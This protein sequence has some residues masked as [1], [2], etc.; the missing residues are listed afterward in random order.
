[1][2]G[3]GGAAEQGAGRILGLGGLLLTVDHAG[4]LVGQDLLGLVQLLVLP[5]GHLVDLLQRQEG[6][7]PNALHDVGVVHVAPVLVELE[8]A[9]LVG[10]QPDRVAGG[11]AHLLALGVGQQGD[12]HGVGVLAQ[13]AADQLGAAQ[14]IAPLVVAA[15]LHVAAVVLEHVVE[16]VALHDH[17]VELEEGQALFHPLLVALGAQHIVDREAGA[18]L[19]QQL[20]VVQL[21]QPVGV[22]QHQGLALAEINEALHLPLEAG[23]VVVDVLFGQHLAHI[24][25]AGGV[26]DHGGAAADQGDGLVAGHLQALHQ[27]QGHE[28]AGG[29]AVGGAVKADVKSGLAL[30]DDVDDLLIGDLGHQAAGFQFV[31]Q[32]HKNI[33]PVFVPSG[34]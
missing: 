29:Q 28:V 9:G 34:G 14:H 5:G 6:Q 31:V 11:L 22:V 33:P 7:H 23:G 20:D 27:G 3:V 2:L 16:V 19:P 12:G 15:E 13:L 8:G 26:A 10:V 32:L 1:M 30:V 24:G 18:H 21:E 17:V 4:Q 25:A